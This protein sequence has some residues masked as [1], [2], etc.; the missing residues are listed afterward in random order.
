MLAKSIVDV[1]K[2]STEAQTEL[3]FSQMQYE[4]STVESLSAVL[5]S[6]S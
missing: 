1:G 3:E 4:E 6:W 5:K 2:D